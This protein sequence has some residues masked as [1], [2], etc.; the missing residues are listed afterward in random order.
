MLDPFQETIWPLGDQ[1]E[2]I[3]DFIVDNFRFIFNDWI[4]QPVGV[5]LRGIQSFFLFLNPIV[6][7]VILLGIAWQIANR[8]LAIFSVVA[9]TVV[10]LIGAWDESMITLALVLTAVFFCVIIGIPLGIW[11]ARS[12]RFASLIRPVLDTMQTLP[13]FVYLVPVVM[14]FGTGEVP[15]V[16]VT[17]I[18]AVPPLIRLTNI[19][20]RGVPED[21]VEA[22]KAFGS[23]PQQVLLQVQVP[24]AMPTILAGVN[25]SLMLALSMVV[26]ASLIAVEGLGQMVNRG[27]GRL[28]VGLA[29][30][31]GIGIVLLAIVL[32][33]ITQAVGSTDKG[34]PHWKQRGPI[35]FV[36][37]LL[38][39]NKAQKIP[40][41]S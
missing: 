23:T 32:D 20:I 28:D 33:R 21:V 18:F 31:G 10:G 34:R 22:A 15:G 2:A 7:L 9:M 4:G 12:D 6:F 36:L 17:F 38:N 13:A 1:I 41:E 30:V 8:N 37:N 26:I 24:L 3:I 25:Q 19:G 39:K 16:I 14:L 27:I 11:A 40:Q 29:A 35:G 5:V